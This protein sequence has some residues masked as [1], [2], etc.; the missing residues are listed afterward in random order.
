[1]KRKMTK[2]DEII[3]V[4]VIYGFGLCWVCIF[5]YQLP[6]LVFRRSIE[7]VWWILIKEFV[8]MGWMRPI[9]KW[10]AVSRL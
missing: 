1:M 8:G 2:R 10:G 9:G 5:Y 3:L 7:W 4:L 6:A